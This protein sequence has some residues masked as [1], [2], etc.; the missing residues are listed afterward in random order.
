MSSRPDS[1]RN[2]T[3]R[4]PTI[5]ATTTATRAVLPPA[6][7][8]PRR[9]DSG[10]RLAGH[11]TRDDVGRHGLLATK[12]VVADHAGAE[13]GQRE[14]GRD[15]ALDQVDVVDGADVVAQ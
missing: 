7:V 9:A 12:A 5:H 11:R 1:S 2:R 3:A 4:K 10:E 14:R 6:G 13:L 15:A 8:A